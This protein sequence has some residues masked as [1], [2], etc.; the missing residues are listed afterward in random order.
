M[1]HKTTTPFNSKEACNQFAT[2]LNEMLKAEKKPAFNYT[3]ANK[4]IIKTLV[5]YF[6]NQKDSGLDLDKGIFL[7]GPVGTGKSAI[8]RAFSTLLSQ[9][10]RFRIVDCRDVQKQAVKD[11]FDS[12]LKYTVHSYT[13]KNGFYHRENGGIVYCFD[14][15]GAE[16]LS[17]FYG[18]EI[19]VMA[20]VLQDRYREFDITRLKTHITSNLKDG[21]LIEEMYSLRVRDRMREMF[22]FVDMPGPSFRK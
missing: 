13:F 17:K 5:H 10:T 4:P 18:N 9:S 14:D 16:K 20:E 19:N 11:G 21:D 15:L 8:M 1:T 22:N 3:E 12:L 7:R 6:C 2:H